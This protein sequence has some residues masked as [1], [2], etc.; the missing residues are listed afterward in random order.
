MQNYREH[1][2]DLTFRPR[3]NPESASMD[4]QSVSQMYNRMILRQAT[5]PANASVNKEGQGKGDNDDLQ[6]ISSGS[7]EEKDA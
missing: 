5:Q 4:L 1:F 3:I 6:D 2:K 7:E